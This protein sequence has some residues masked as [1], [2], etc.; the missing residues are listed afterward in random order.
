MVGEVSEVL[1]TPPV[2]IYVTYPDQRVTLSASEIERIRATL[3]PL[4]P[5]MT[6]TCQCAEQHTLARVL[7]GDGAVHG[8]TI[9]E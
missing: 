3:P 9:K 5:S 1:P 4:P 7:A 8:Q 6:I 2:G